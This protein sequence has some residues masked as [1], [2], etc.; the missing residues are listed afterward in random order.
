LLM[1]RTLTTQQDAV[2]AVARGK[3]HAH[4]R[5]LYPFGTIFVKQHKSLKA[6]SPAMAAGLSD[7]L[8][9]MNDLAEIIDGRFRMLRKR[10]SYKKG[11]Q[12]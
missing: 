5:A 1:R 3:T 8:W 12:Q 4:G 6:L 10:G 9:S 2:A 7:T 11:D